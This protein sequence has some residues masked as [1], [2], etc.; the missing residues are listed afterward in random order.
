M[1]PNIPKDYVDKASLKLT[2]LMMTI[3]RWFLSCWI[4]LK[5]T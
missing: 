1:V 3:P 5:T 2:E 4:E